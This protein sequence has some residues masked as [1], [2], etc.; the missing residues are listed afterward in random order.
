MAQRPVEALRSLIL[1]S[2]GALLLA[3]WPSSASAQQDCPG[4]PTS[5]V[6]ESPS[7]WPES[8]RR[9][10]RRAMQTELAAQGVREVLDPPQREKAGSIIRVASECHPG[11]SSVELSVQNGDHRTRERIELR[12]VDAGSTERVLALAAA[13]L[14]VRNCREVATAL[15]AETTTMPPV[16]AEEPVPATPSSASISTP[17]TPTGASHFALSLAPEFVAYRSPFTG[18][19]RVSIGLHY[20]AFDLEFGV[21]L[22]LGEVTVQHSLGRITARSTGVHLGLSKNLIHTSIG[23][24]RAGVRSELGLTT[25]EGHASANA[26]LSDSTRGLTW[27]L[28]IGPELWVPLAGRLS[29]LVALHGGLGGGVPIAAGGKTVATTSGSSLV[30]S[31]GLRLRL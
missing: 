18:L 27:A 9:D 13:E 23:I 10:L 21:G 24:L 31:A 30:I 17:S 8:Q 7:C 15:Q 22:S 4:K 14:V 25:A 26:T 11:E 20:L 2:L 12:D 1:V 16:S 19:P 6:L 29:G 3:L 5:I 28:R